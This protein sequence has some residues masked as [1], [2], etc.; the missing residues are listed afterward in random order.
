HHYIRGTWGDWQ[1]FFYAL[2]KISAGLCIFL[3]QRSALL[4]C[5]KQTNTWEI[6]NIKENKKVDKRNMAIK[7]FTPKDIFN[8]GEKGGFIVQGVFGGFRGEE[9]NMES[10]RL[11]VVFQKNNDNLANIKI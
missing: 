1:V 6:I 8:I 11:L 9:F 10:D 3:L 2:I 7:F 5:N 4:F